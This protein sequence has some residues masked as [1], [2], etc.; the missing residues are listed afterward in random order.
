M[1]SWSQ[2]HSRNSH[3]SQVP[4]QSTILILADSKAYKLIWSCLNQGTSFQTFRICSFKQDL[5]HFVVI[6]GNIQSLQILLPYF[7]GKIYY[8]QI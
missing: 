2:Q 4:P 3:I 5:S 1:V 8:I 7:Y 6:N